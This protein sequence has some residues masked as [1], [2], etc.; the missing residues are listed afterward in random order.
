MAAAREV[1]IETPP[2]DTGV[3]EG[4]RKG[5]KTTRVN[6]LFAERFAI[7]EKCRNIALLVVERLENCAMKVG[8][9]VVGSGLKN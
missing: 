9:S 6:S 1:R 8:E 7:Q 2:A 4:A 5:K 3:S